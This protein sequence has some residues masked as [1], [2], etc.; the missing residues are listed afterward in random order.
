[1]LTE[2]FNEEYFGIKI[3]ETYYHGYKK[4]QTTI[5]E[6]IDADLYEMSAI[7]V[8]LYKP[9]VIAPMELLLWNTKLYLQIKRVKR[10]Y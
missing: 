9:Q 2:F 10:Y 8:D 1:M 7:E 5:E 4:I 3:K 6:T